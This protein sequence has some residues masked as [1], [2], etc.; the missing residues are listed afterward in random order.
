MI[1]VVSF[2][3]EGTLVDMTFSDMVWNEGLPKL[4]ALKA[5]LSLAEARRIVLGEYAR[6]GEN[7]IEWYDVYYWFRR[8]ELPDDPKI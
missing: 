2:D 4:Y 7:R 1:R 6:V 5:G 3:L 8:F